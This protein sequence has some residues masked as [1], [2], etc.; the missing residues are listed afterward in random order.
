MSEGNAAPVAETPAQQADRL[1]QSMIGRFIDRSINT[2]D[3]GLP[4]EQRKGYVLLIFDLD[5]EGNVKVG[6]QVAIQ[7]NEVK[8]GTAQVILGTVFQGMVKGEIKPADPVPA[9]VDTA[10]SSESTD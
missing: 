6:S 10:P 4:K 1:K 3:N 9:P 8:L 5:A 2:H 7:S